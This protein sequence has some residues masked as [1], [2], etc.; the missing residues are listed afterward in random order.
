ML[1]RLLDG[2]GFAGDFDFLYLP[3]DFDRKAWESNE[4]STSIMSDGLQ[5]QPGLCVRQPSEPGESLTRRD[6]TRHEEVANRLWATFD[7][8]TSWSIPSTKA[9]HSASFVIKMH[10]KIGSR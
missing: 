9:G 5:G 10:L 4:R 3:V 6:L 2:N 7:N 8:F 1:I